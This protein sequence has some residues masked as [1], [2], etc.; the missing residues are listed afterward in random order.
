MATLV[1]N[2]GTSSALSIV[3]QRAGTAAPRL[4]GGVSPSFQGA[5]R[6]TV[7]GQAKVIPILASYVDT[8]TEAA[9]QAAFYN[10]A[11][12][13]CSGDILQNIQTLCSIDNVV[14][15][16]IPS[17]AG[18][19]EMSFTVNEVNA[20]T[21]LLK[22]TPGDTITGEAFT[23]STV[24]YSHNAAGGATPLSQAAIDVKRD[25]HWLI[26]VRSLLLE[27]ARTNQLLWSNDFSNAAWAKT[28]CTI[29]TG[30]ADPASGSTACTLTATGANSH[31]L[32][33]LA[34]G[35]SLV[36]T[37]SIWLRR[38]TG[39]GVVFLR[40]APNTGFV[41]VGTGLSATWT[42]FSLTAAAS[43]GRNLDIQIATNG[44]AVDAWMGDEEDGAFASSEIATTT[45]ALARGADTYSLPFTPAP[46][47]LT[48]YIKFVELGTLLTQARVFEIGSA[49][50]A[51]PRFL[52][53]ASGGFYTAL[54]HNGTA[55]VT[56]AL[57]VAPAINDVVELVVRLYADGSVDITQTINGATAT[58]ST[59]SAAN[60]LSTAWAGQLCY[61][62]S[63]GTTGGGVGFIAIRSFKAC[64]GARSLTEMRAA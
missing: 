17:L 53:F 59:Q 51:T 37:N 7:R 45:G 11:Q 41:D 54:H 22:Y 52:C 55:Q 36:R 31:C 18:F 49:A 14:S 30:I 26:G 40:D 35:A 2:A 8:A 9:I 44:D 60:P 27:A 29:T 47:E 23:R 48:V 5:L 46:V 3:C 63:I 42:R 15:N 39:T 13:P 61:L 10:G 20:S 43:T 57:G 33:T 6:S 34:A 28:T 64:A 4:V 38:R 16:M 12:I 19:F 25:N 50:G 24:A 32:Q 58:V 21:I 56:S 1:L 62:N